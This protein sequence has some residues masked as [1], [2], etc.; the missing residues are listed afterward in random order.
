MS[1]ELAYDPDELTQDQVTGPPGYMQAMI[2]TKRGQRT[3]QPVPV[4]WSTKKGGRSPPSVPR[5]EL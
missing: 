3:N 4:L 2:L 1:G 5:R